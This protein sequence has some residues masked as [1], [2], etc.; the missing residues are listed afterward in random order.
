MIL[1]SIPD[2]RL[3]W[4][5]DPRFLSQFQQAATTDTAERSSR[6]TTFKPYSRYPACFKDVSFWLPPQVEGERMH[7]NDLCDLVR[8][9]AGDL[10]EDVKMVKYIFSVTCVFRTLT[11]DVRLTVS[12][13]QNLTGQVY[14]IVSTIDPWIGA[15]LTTKSKEPLAHL[16]RRSLSNDETNA[17]HSDVIA[18]LKDQFR[19][20]IR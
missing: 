12:P 14:V 17:L 20:E 7:E 18:R 13:I 8:D 15:C 6:I 19:V 5:T 10:V 3:F 16:F 2:I 4:S 9:V 1:N 11:N